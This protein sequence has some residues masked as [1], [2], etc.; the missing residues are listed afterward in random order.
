MVVA[1]PTTEF[2]VSSDAEA[3]DTLKGLE[4]PAEFSIEFLEAM[5]TSPGEVIGIDV[6]KYQALYNSKTGKYTYMDWD[7]ASKKVHFAYIKATEAN[8]YVDPTWLHNCDECLRLGIPFGSYHYVRANHDWK[9]QASWFAS[10]IRGSLPPVIDVETNSGLTKAALENWLIKFIARVEELCGK[11]VMIYTSAGFWDYNVPRNDW[12]K[13]KLLW[14]ANYTSGTKPL[15]PK[16]WGAIN[17]PKEQTIWQYSADG[18]NLGSYYGAWSDDIDLNRFNGDEGKFEKVFGVKPNIPDEE[19]PPTPEPGDSPLKF[20]VMVD[21]LNV[22]TGPGIT[23][24][25]I[26]DINAGD[27][28]TALNVGGKDCW[29]EIEPGKW[30]AANYNGNQYL[31]RVV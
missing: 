30:V 5:S 21:V 2:V 18:N 9:K 15:L 26:G 8:A 27:V 17:N 14:V 16:D 28:V 1:Y 4:F 7:E 20:T 19:E 12:A 3:Y 29:I 22:R 23:Y 10:H 24:K 13:T 31:K 25:D 6:S 11:E